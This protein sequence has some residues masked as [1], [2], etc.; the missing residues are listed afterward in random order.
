MAEKY[1]V[2]PKN[3]TRAWWEY[4]WMY[5]KWHTLVTVFIIAAVAITVYQKATAPKYDLN[6]VYAGGGVIAE[7]T[8]QSLTKELTPL[9]DDVNQNGEKLLNLYS[10]QMSGSGDA[11]YDMA[12]Q[13]KL[14]LTLSADEVYIYLMDGDVAAGFLSE[15]PS[16]C[17][18]APLDTWCTRDFSETAICSGDV[19]VG[20][21]LSEISAFDET[22]L[23]AD[24]KYMLVRYAPREDQKEQ[25]A[26]YAAAIKLAEKLVNGAN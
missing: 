12:M 7:E 23:S 3:F 13:T 4:F 20:V 18:F 10:M 22:P 14:T 5:Y 9:I 8:I 24:D 26:G 16:D 19:P 25:K 17:V 1:G 15:D 2:V 21:P 6:V 11:E